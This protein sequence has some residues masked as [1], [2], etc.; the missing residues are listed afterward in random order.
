[1]RDFIEAEAE[2][3][4]T[5]MEMSALFALATLA[6]VA[7]GRVEVQPRPGWSEGLNLFVVVAMEPGSRK[8][9]AH[10][11]L[12]APVN[13]YEQEL[14]AEALP[15]IAEKASQ[16]RRAEQRL[17][18]AER[19]A[20]HA[21]ASERVQ[22]ER[23]ADDLVRDLADCQVPVAPRLFTADCTPE[24]L[25]SLLCEQGGRMSVLAAEGGVFDILAGRYSNGVANLDA[26]LCGH[27][28]DQLRVDRKGRPPEF[29][30][31]PA[32]TVGLA[33]QPYVLAR[34]GTNQD[35]SERGLLARF[36][37]AV[38][39]G[40]V[41]YRNMEPAPMPDAVRERYETAVIGLA[42]TV[43]AF[44]PKLVLT[45]ST[46]ALKALTDWSWELEPRRRPSGDL[47]II[48]GWASK[49]EGATVR[50]AGLLHVSL[51]VS[52]NL[53]DNAVITVETM[54]AAIEVARCLVAHAHVAF[55]AMGAD[56]HVEG[57][58]RIVGWAQDQRITHFTRRDCHQAH[59]NR[60]PK[61]D[62]L[63]PALELLEDTGWVRRRPAPQPTDRGGR[64][65]SPAYDVNPHALTHNPHNTHNPGERGG[66]ECSES[67]E[68]Q[69]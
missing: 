36:L 50:I 19:A 69:T 23:E 34:A 10:R 41:G 56:P 60:F 45:L 25:A 44:N 5:P 65:P 47:G 62:D 12:T 22:L 57:A 16:R 61:P 26:F 43:E 48:Q 17:A 63:D 1:L 8:S 32:L 14:M 54:T 28:G 15:V 67:S 58:R 35:M 38:P 64:P 27:A 39:P 68:Y 11:D 31:H 24:A 40:N 55:D 30:Q 18:R 59:R 49:L 13:A 7:G 3:T 66:S 33:V 20:A 53:T 52:T 9:R 2:A 6:T 4:Q 21:H 37:Y 51:H 42:R 29:V 46:E